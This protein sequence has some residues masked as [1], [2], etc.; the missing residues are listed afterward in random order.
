M[1]CY[2]GISVGNQERVYS[3]DLARGFAVLF[4]IMVHTLITYSNNAVMNSLFGNVVD[5]LGSPPGAPVFMVAMGI[6]C[7]YS[8]KNDFMSGIKRGLSII[9]LGYV[10]NFLRGVLPVLLLNIFD[11]LLTKS[12]PAEILNMY[13]AMR[14][15]DILQ[16]A[17]ISL[18]IMAFIRKYNLNKY[19]LLGTAII[20]AIGSQYLWG[21]KT[22]NNLLNFILDPFWGNEPSPE[23]CIGNII[24]FPFFPWFSFVLVGMFFGDTL[25]NSD[26]TSVIIKT[27]GAI[28]AAAVVV[29]LIVFIRNHESHIQLNDYYHCKP[30]YILFALGFT[31]SWLYV[32]DL[33]AKKIKGT[34]IFNILMYW[35]KNVTN[36]YII[37]W[38][39]IMWGAFFV[40]GFNKVG[41]G[42]TVFLILVISVLS[43][44]LSQCYLKLKTRFPKSV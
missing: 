39:V 29:S 41:Y 13:D 38:I 28:G 7:Y 31:F 44:L 16:F 22:Q 4:M 43:H 26:N 10:L 25:K 12:I 21:I 2:G 32:C 33:L 19:I 36:I 40:F 9:M 23:E 18:I 14:T 8:R 20:I 24:S 17:G 3:V 11:P 34:V 5:F 27:F 15:I 6:S 42:M 35:S 1:L 30:W 37:Q